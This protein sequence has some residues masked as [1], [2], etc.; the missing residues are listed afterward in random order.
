[1]NE[2]DRLILKANDL[3]DTQ[4]HLTR[5]VTRA[6]QRYCNGLTKDQREAIKEAGR[7]AFVLGFLAGKSDKI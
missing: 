6:I 7:A 2:E 1:M 5:D 4:K 3:W